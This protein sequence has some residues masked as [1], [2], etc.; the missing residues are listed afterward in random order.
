MALLMC[1]GCPEEP[2]PQNPSSPPNNA[3]DGTV[4]GHS[5]GQGDG[6]LLD[7]GTT[8]GNNA[9]PEIDAGGT[10][11]QSLPPVTDA[12]NTVS[13]NPADSGP[14]IIDSGLFDSGTISQDLVDS[15]LVSDAGALSMSMPDSGPAV[16]IDAGVVPSEHPFISELFLD[17]INVA[18]TFV[19]I[20]GKSGT[21]LSNY[22]IAFLDNAGA[23]LEL[24][25]Y[26][27]TETIPEEVG[28]F[29]AVS[30]SPHNTHDGGALEG[31]IKA[32]ALIY[33]YDGSLET[34]VEFLSV[35]IT[36]TAADGIAPC[37]ND[38]TATLLNQDSPL[39]FGESLQL[40]R[41]VEDGYRPS[42]SAHWIK[43]STTS[44]GTLNTNLLT[45]S[46]IVNVYNAPTNVGETL[47]IRGNFSADGSHE[48]PSW[49]A[50][51]AVVLGWNNGCNCW[52]G[53]FSWWTLQT[54]EYKL[55]IQRPDSDDWW[56]AGNNR[57]LFLTDTEET[58][59]VINDWQY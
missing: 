7:S 55:Y 2:T 41:I 14:P 42:N 24:K 47:Y 46:V 10:D 3:S 49:E 30:L 5:D 26:L 39:S 20:S 33:D 35:D 45:T 37:L 29:G 56:E 28:G 18:N 48:P 54:L 21:D 59:L 4:D 57:Q 9:N 19:E 58:N 31:T 38:T 50:A 15:G 1:I 44:P 8:D 13:S 23:L 17:N 11:G 51:S 12:G 36:I 40:V 34:L 22:W 32:A 52:S 16:T 43:R 6:A 25:P 53:A 27:P